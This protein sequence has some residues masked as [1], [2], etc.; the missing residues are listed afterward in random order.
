MKSTYPTAK[1]VWLYTLSGGIIDGIL[2]GLIYFMWFDFFLITLI[3]M[4][5]GFLIGLLSALI[6][7]TTLAYGQFYRHKKSLL[8][9]FGIGFLVTMISAMIVMFFLDALMQQEVIIFCLLMGLAGGISAVLTGLF[10][11]P[12]KET[13]T[14]KFD[15]LSSETM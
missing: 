13:Q 11:L 9:A 1:V 10:A 3:A 14:E 8:I 5:F 15:S 6:T 7:G 2:L 4:S 12:K